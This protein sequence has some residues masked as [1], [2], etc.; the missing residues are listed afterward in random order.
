MKA[1]GW[2]FWYHN[3]SIA[4]GSFVIAVV[5]MIR[6]VFEYIVKQYEAAGM[7]DN[8]IFKIVTCCIRCVLWC[9]DKY[10]KFITKNAYIQI[11]LSSNSFCSSALSA[12][13]LALRHAGRFGSAAIIGT[14]MMVLGKATIVGTS[15]WLTLVVVKTQYPE[16]QQ[17]MLPAAIVA[18]VA[19]LVAGL[20]LSIFSFSCTAILHCFILDEDTGGSKHTP[21][22]LQS[23]LDNCDEKPAPKKEEKAKEEE[24]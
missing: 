20:F 5:T 23:F 16:V 9:L 24:E 19:Y 21:D 6:V 4:F 10:V 12:F 1:T 13:W 8:V 22:S 7:K 15:A 14:I 3:G 18:A 11:A 17:P 2:G